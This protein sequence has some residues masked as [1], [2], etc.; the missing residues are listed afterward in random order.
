[1]NPSL[2]IHQ[3]VILCSANG[4]DNDTLDS[5]K[6]AGIDGN[7]PKPLDINDFYQLY[8]DIEAEEID[9]GVPV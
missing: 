1:M 9:F 4:D 2:K 7:L 3:K 8:M 6:E 5:A